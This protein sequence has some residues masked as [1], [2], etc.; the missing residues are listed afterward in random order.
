MEKIFLP[1][2]NYFQKRRIA[3]Y[4]IFLSCFLISDYFASRIQLEEDISKILPGDKKI[5]RLNE[6]FQ[7]SKFLEKLVITV[8]M[9]D[10]TDTAQPDSL[11]VF[12]DV[13]VLKLNEKLKPYIRSIQ[14]KVDDALALEMFGSIHDNL[15]I[16]LVAYCCILNG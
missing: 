7:D 1:I 11:V 15:P 14:D 3:F 8:S 9:K 4:I 16:Y 13:F 10:T 2:F 5:Q 12:A 6:V